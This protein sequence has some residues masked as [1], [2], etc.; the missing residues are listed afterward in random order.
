MYIECPS[1]I[2]IFFLAE[3]LTFVTF[4]YMAD[5]QA[6]QIEA[7]GMLK[8]KEMHFLSEPP[9]WGHLPFFYF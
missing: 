6:L 9:T 3:S 2:Q 7:T 4:L 5:S 8:E 1:A